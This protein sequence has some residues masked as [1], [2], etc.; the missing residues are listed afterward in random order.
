MA[1]RRSVYDFL[2]QIG[3]RVDGS[4][5]RAVRKATDSARGIGQELSAGFKAAADNAA[6]SIG[7]IGAVIGAAVGADAVIETQTGFAK[8]QAQIGATTEEM[9]GL[10]EQAKGIYA[11]GLV[12]S[13]EEANGIISQIERS[14]G[15][16]FAA[17][18]EKLVQGSATIGFTY[19]VGAE[20]LARVQKTLTGTFGEDVEHTLDLLA[21]GFQN[22]LDYSGEFLDTLNEYGPQF[23]AA[24]YTADEMFNILVA[25]ADAGAWNLDKVGDA[26]KEFGIRIKDG[27]KTTE[28]AI[29]QLSKPTGN[30]YHDM[31][32]G[33]ANVSDVMG[34][35]TKELSRMKDQTKAFQIAQGLFGTMSEDLTL[36]TLYGLQNV[37][38][39]AQDAT[40]TLERM[41]ETLSNDAGVR[42]QAAMNQMQTSLGDIGIE[43]L[44][45][46]VPAIEALTGGVGWLSEQFVGLS[47]NAKTAIVVVG[48]LAAGIGV[49]VPLVG[50]GISVFGG[51]GAAI[52]GVSGVIGFMTGPVGIAI[53]AIGGLIAVGV[54]LYKNWDA[55][56]EKAQEVSSGIVTFF[57]TAK[58]GVIG[59]V[60]GGI[61]GAIDF[62][63]KGIGSLNQ[64]AIDIPDWVP[65]VGGKQFGFQ[66][67]TIPALASGGIATQPTLAMIGEG[68]EEEAVLPLSKLDQLLSGSSGGLVINNYF[69]VNGG[70]DAEA[71]AREIAELVNRQIAQY[72]HQQKRLSFG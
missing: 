31:L 11:T 40:G 9:V 63:N 23:K 57:V 14:A 52:G 42:A 21:Y 12:G 45:V 50:A 27:S 54:L 3:G 46:A 56:K 53:A 35:V 58:D 67:P 8:L 48:G 59:A 29:K 69:T 19:D 10:K 24:G 43:I 34:A 51:I 44:N 41:T 6:A 47:P 7:S 36:E 70:K 38:S 32:K 30:L 16:L 26:A 72:F 65:A 71:S 66:I 5:T 64:L 4:F 2:M 28:D 25:G 33:N 68:G 15:K 13:M 61:N 18:K 49:L 1:G 62:V 20:E 37:N 22:N 55:I 60:K 17:D 39:A